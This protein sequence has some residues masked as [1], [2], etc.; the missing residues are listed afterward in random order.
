MFPVQIRITKTPKTL[1]KVADRSALSL[2]DFWEEEMS[3]WCTPSW[4]TDNECKRSFPALLTAL[5]SNNVGRPTDFESHLFNTSCLPLS[6]KRRKEEGGDMKN[7]DAESA[8]TERQIKVCTWLREMSSCS[9]LT[10]LP[11]PAWVL[12]SKTCKPLFAPL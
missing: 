10:V 1:W 3:T 7:E 5:H 6:N 8:C 2:I 11:G 9:C 12:L 4:A